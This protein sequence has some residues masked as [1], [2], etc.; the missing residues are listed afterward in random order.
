V[1]DRQ[2]PPFPREP[3]PQL[4]GNGQQVRYSPSASHGTGNR[5]RG[6]FR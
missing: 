4:V 3:R 6:R 2:G 1:P 5:R